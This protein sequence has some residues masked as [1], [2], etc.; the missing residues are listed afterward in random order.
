LGRHT[1]IRVTPQRLQAAQ[2]HDRAAVGEDDQETK[3]R[4]YVSAVGV[5]PDF[6]QGW[7]S[8]GHRLGDMGLLEA[9]A[10]AYRRVLE[11]STDLMDDQ[12]G[13]R[14]SLMTAQAWCNLAMRL[15]HMGDD[16]A[17]R[18]ALNC[19]QLEPEMAFGWTNLAMIRSRQGD[20]DGAIAAGRRAFRLGAEKP[21][22]ELGL[23]FALLFAGQFAEGLKHFEARFAYKMQGYLKYPYPRWSGEVLS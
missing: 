3:Y 17:E 15:H 4:L 5:D 1:E 9:S 6:A 22:N 18:A 12:P 23:A 10:A 16:F 21:E 13:A 20:H 8:L 11:C 2:M 7:M 19:V 14:T